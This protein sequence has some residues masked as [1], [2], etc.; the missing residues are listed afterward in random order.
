MWQSGKELVE[1]PRSGDL[2]SEDSTS[3]GDYNNPYRQTFR[4]F[5]ENDL[6]QKYNEMNPSCS[7]PR[8]QMLVS[9]FRS[10]FHIHGNDIVLGS[11]CASGWETVALDMFELRAFFVVLNADTSRVPCCFLEKFCPTNVDLTILED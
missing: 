5:S 10:V 8:S 3:S 11:M 2:L 1:V 6:N 7:S 9:Q 4:Y